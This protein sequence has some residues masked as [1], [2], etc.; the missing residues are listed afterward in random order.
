MDIE[1]KVKTATQ[2]EV[3]IFILDNL[4]VELSRPPFTVEETDTIA[5]R[6]Y[7]FVW[8]SAQGNDLLAAQRSTAE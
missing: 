6:V 3:K 5:E 8:R 2:A 1:Q 4:Y 7:D